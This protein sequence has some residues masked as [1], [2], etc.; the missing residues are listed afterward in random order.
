MVLFEI[1]KNKKSDPNIHQN[2]PNCTIYKNFLRGHA[3]EPPSI[4]YGFAMRS[5]SLRDMQISKSQKKK[6][7][8]PPPPKSWGRPCPILNLTM[9][10]NLNPSSKSLHRTDRPSTSSLPRRLWQSARWGTSQVISNKGYS[11]F[12]STLITDR[13]GQKTVGN[14]RLVED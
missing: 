8:A 2:A 3:P 9:K 14:E 4:A 5:M 1:L 12:L 7:L 13:Y 6:F 11:S 10:D